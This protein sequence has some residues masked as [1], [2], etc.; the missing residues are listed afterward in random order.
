MSPSLTILALQNNNLSGSIPDSWG[1]EVMGNNIINQTY[2]L[3]ILTL[4]H[5]LISGVIPVSL[6]KMGFLQE[7]SLSHNQIKGSIP[8]ELGDIISF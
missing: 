7:L 5:N 1:S 8:S 6:G 4:D 2:S 3:Q